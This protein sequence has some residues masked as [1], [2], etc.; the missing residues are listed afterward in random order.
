MTE[1]QRGTP[2]GEPFQDPDGGPWRTA[3]EQA[4]ET[5]LFEDAVEIAVYVKG[6]MIHTK[7]D[8]ATLARIMAILTGMGA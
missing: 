1:H 4:I 3:A 6:R 7:T 5:E 2:L 8:A